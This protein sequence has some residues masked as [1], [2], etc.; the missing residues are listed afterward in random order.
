MADSKAGKGAKGAPPKGGK[1]A[2]KGAP[3]TATKAKQPGEGG[4]GGCERSAG[5]TASPPI[6][7]RRRITRRG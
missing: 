1:D 7:P 5:P 4:G 2:A 3:K 6:S